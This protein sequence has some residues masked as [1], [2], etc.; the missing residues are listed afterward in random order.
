MLSGFGR[1]HLGRRALEAGADAYVEKGSLDLV[2][3]ADVFPP[4][5]HGG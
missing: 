5:R 2:T 3:V 4:G 1:E